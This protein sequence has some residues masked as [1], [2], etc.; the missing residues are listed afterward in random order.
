MVTAT[1]SSIKLNAL[2]DLRDFRGSLCPRGWDQDLIFP[3][4]GELR[5]MRQGGIGRSMGR[6]LRSLVKKKPRITGLSAQFVDWFSPILRATEKL[7]GRSVS[8]PT[9]SGEPLLSGSE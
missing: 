6:S 9:A 7:T 2:S 5:R 3:Y 1:I 8:R 4:S